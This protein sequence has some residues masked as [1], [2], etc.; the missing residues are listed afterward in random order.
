MSNIL[1]FTPIIIAI[2]TFILIIG[3]II[4]IKNN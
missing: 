4:H 2:I 1:L 3:F